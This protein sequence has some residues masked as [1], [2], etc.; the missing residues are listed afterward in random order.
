MTTQ[1]NTSFL[2]KISNFFGQIFDAIV[3]AR[4]KQA[5]ME[6]A[7]QLKAHHS[8]FKHMSVIDIYHRITNDVIKERE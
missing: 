4:R 1:V 2:R 5:A 8:D 3:E 7:V 6:T